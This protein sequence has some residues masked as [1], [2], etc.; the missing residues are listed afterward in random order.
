M[1]YIL[2]IE[3]QP[4]IVTKTQEVKIFKTINIIIP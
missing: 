2:T 4:N 3:T 1:T